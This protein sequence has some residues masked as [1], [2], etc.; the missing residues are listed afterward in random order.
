MRVARFFL[1]EILIGVLH[2]DVVSLPCSLNISPNKLTGVLMQNLTRVFCLTSLA[3]LLL[4][5]P[6]FAASDIGLKGIGPCLGF[7]DPEGALDGTVEFGVDFELGT[8]TKQ[9]YWDASAMFWRAGQ[10][11]RYIN[12]NYDWKLRDFALRSGV[13]YHF[14]EG[15][16]EP[17]AGGGVGIHFRSW[18]Y[19]GYDGPAFDNSETDFG[20][21]IQGGLE[22]E[23]NSKTSGDV[24]LQFDLADPDQTAL[25]FQV[26]FMLG[27]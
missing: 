8:L 13:D 19:A 27:K 4:S 12:R 11:Y 16:L 6:S 22:Y 17:Y 7:I 21:Y 1:L 10:E 23:F 26:I 20:I 25:V 15:E 9:L 3:F 5:Q 18:D 14:V 24:K 2:I